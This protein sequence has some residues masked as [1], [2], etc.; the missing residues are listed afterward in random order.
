MNNA[1]PNESWRYCGPSAGIAHTSVGRAQIPQCTVDHCGVNAQEVLD[2]SDQEL[3]AQCG[4]HS[5][6]GQT[7]EAVKH[8]PFPTRNHFLCK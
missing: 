7:F 5:G 1:V 8:I 6:R 4:P 2:A 3:Q